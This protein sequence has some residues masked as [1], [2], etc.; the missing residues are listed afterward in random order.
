MGLMMEF[1][2]D[3]I[4]GYRNFLTFMTYLLLVGAIFAFASAFYGWYYKPIMNAT[5]TAILGFLMLFVAIIM[6]GFNMVVDTVL[7]AKIRN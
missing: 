1:K 3:K 2:E 7:H 5:T 4:E 6:A